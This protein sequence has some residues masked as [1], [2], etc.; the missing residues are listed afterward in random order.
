MIIAVPIAGELKFYPFSGADLRVNMGMPVFFFFLL[1]SRKIHPI[2]SGFLTGISVVF[3][4]MTLDR[5]QVGSFQ[6]HNS[7]SSHFPAFFYYLIFASF[8]HFFKVKNLNEQPLLIGLFGIVLEFMSNSA[9][10]L[11]R[12][13]TTNMQITVAHFLIIAGIAIIRSF[14]VLG[15]YNIVILREARVAEEQQRM[16]NDQI[17]LLISNLY[18]E[19]VQLQKSTKNAEELTSA[20]YR[21][22]RQLKQLKQ[23]E[24]AQAMLKIAGEVHEIKKD[25]QRIYA[26]LSKLMAK[27]KINDFMSIKEIIDI[28]VRA[29]NNYGEMLGKTID[30]KV[31]I[32]GDHPQYRTFTLFSLIN[33]L[34]A[35]AVE[36]IDQ[37]GRI[38]LTVERVADIVKIS[39]ND[40]GSGISPKNKQYIFEPGFTTK[41]DQTGIAS[42]GIGLSYIKNVIENSGGEMKLLDSTKTDGTTFEI[43]LPVASLIKKGG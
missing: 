17:L 1:W 28:I 26:G 34:V 32:F 11:I 33:N 18:V 24:P 19:M 20:S 15:F 8:F 21:L 42:N 2:F 27:E 22:Y 9:E 3:F 14:F 39:V 38:V 13:F 12:H 31:K 43:Q 10:M 36:A 41:F 6:F 25:N 16:R 35:N 30:Y 4:R 40:N 29:N 23:H 7:F 5:L 37:T